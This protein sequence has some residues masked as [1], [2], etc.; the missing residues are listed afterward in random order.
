[1]AT[2]RPDLATCG[3]RRSSFETGKICPVVPTVRQIADTGPMG[4]CAMPVQPFAW[5]RRVS[6]PFFAAAER[7]AWLRLDASL[8]MLGL[9]LLFVGIAGFVTAG[10]L[11]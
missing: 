7:S 1:M 11:L 10:E 4:L 2:P 5:R 9:A 6:E 3:C 8:D